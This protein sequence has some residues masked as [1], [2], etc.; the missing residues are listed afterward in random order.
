ML[1]AW[2]QAERGTREEHIQ[3]VNKTFRKPEDEE[4]LSLPR[5]QACRQWLLDQG[6]MYTELLGKE[7]PQ[8][9]GE[10]AEPIAT[11]Y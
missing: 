11:L 6:E 5:R 1:L 3:M 7:R 4:E 9:I 10:P 8:D 2:L